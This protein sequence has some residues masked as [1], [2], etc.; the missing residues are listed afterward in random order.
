MDI[1]HLGWDKAEGDEDYKVVANSK[2]YITEKPAPNTTIDSSITSTSC[3][4]SF[5]PRPAIKTSSSM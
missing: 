2:F 5:E 4:K 3:W 1:G